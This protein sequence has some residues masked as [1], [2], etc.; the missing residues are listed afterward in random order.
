LALAGDQVDDEALFGLAR[1]PGLVLGAALA[2]RLEGGHVELALALL[3]VVAG[4]AVLLED[5]GHVVDEADPPL[6]RLGP[7]RG[8]GAE[9][10]Q[11]GQGQADERAQDAVAT[12][13][14]QHGRQ[15]SLRGWDRYRRAG[16]GGWRGRQRRWVYYRAS[17]AR[18]ASRKTG[19]FGEL[20]RAFPSASERPRCLPFRAHPLSGR[21]REID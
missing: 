7:G 9:Q 21:F 2:Q 17:A 3:A 14:M 12:A 19:S 10:Q 20:A 13:G 4:E 16:G 1:F 5:G 6:G 15:D 18:M 8:R 11:D